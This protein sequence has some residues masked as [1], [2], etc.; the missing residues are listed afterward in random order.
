ML[1]RY[2]IVNG[3]T[4]A[5]LYAG[6]YAALAPMMGVIKSAQGMFDQ[7]LAQSPIFGPIVNKIVL[8]VS[9]L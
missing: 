6:I 3:T 4:T 7:Y 2:L 5:M 9:C 8:V 1:R